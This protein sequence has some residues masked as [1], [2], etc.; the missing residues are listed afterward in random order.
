[1][2]AGPYGCE[3]CD[4]AH[5]VTVLV[6]WLKGGATVSVCDEDFAPAMINV[7]AVD[8]GVDPTKFYES[9][10]RF[11]DREAK[12]QA[13]TPEQSTPDAE[14]ADGPADGGDATPPQETDSDEEYATL[15]AEQLAAAD[16]DDDR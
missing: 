15:Q 5:P 4:G 7:L 1:M 12:A 13:R 3:F 8:M 6:T 2:A 11:V 16:L 9:V 14:R 10:R